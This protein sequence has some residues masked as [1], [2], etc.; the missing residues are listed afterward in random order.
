MPIFFKYIDVTMLLSP[1]F[2]IH[3]VGVVYCNMS[4]MQTIYVILSNHIFAHCLEFI[5][6]FGMTVPEMSLISL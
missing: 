6:E 1:P 4:K 2:S 3:S 5:D